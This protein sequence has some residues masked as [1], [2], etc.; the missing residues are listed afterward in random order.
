[1]CIIGIFREILARFEMPVFAEACA[2]SSSEIQAGWNFSERQA[3]HLLGCPSSS[4]R[5]KNFWSLG[6]VFE[7]DRLKKD[8]GRQPPQ[9]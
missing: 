8:I 3:G 6:S 4:P 5:A 7:L 2:R 1:L 9:P